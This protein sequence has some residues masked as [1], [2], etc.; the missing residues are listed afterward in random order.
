MAM[1]SKH[2]LENAPPPSLRRPD[3]MIPPALDQLVLRAMAKD[4]ASRPATMDQFSELLQA[5][6]ATLPPDPNRSAGMSVQQGIAT[7]V[8][9]SSFQAPVVPPPAAPAY[10]PP[11]LPPQAAFTPPPSPP[12][13]AFAPASSQ[14][15]APVAAAPTLTSR[16][17]GT[18][19]SKLP[20]WIVLGALALGGAGVGVW[21][22]TRDQGEIDTAASK[23][24]KDPWAEP[25]EPADPDDKDEAD[26]SDKPV[27]TWDSPTPQPPAKDPWAPEGAVT[28]TPPPSKVTP[29]QHTP[30]TIGTA[31]TPI[32]SGAKLRVGPG[33]TSQVTSQGHVHVNLDK[34]IVIALAPLNAGTNDPD[35]LAA[36]WTSETGVTA[37]GSMKITSA[38]KL[39]PALG[40]VGQ[41]NGTPVNQVVVLY[42]EP[43][44][45]LGVLYQAPSTSF[46][47][48]SFQKSVTAWFA[49]NVVLP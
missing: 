9:P 1:L 36:Q 24:E 20:I 26:G 16:P 25:S 7:P 44:Y 43:A 15:P 13:G 14:Q 31:A 12:P 32:P 29:A 37:T 41:V 19:K 6:L 38:G 2:L 42:I 8:A 11:A 45:R 40:F 34:G 27:D 23:P 47:N 46:T 22:A 4:A 39:R 33:F 48:E 17:K 35:E 49:R 28:P 30:K 5:L 21:L 18:S 10:P 3:L